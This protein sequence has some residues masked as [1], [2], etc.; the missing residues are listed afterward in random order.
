M[1]EEQAR[2]CVYCGSGVG[3]FERD[4][5]WP[6]RFGGSDAPENRE[7]SCRRCNRLKSH[8]LWIPLHRSGVLLAVCWE[9][10][11]VI[12]PASVGGD[13]V[14]DLSFSWGA[15]AWEAG[16]LRKFALAR[17]YRPRALRIARVIDR[18]KRQENRDPETVTLIAPNGR[19]SRD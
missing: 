12:V 5:V 16:R 11:D 7:W 6:K 8:R 3:P 17:D 14:H 15:A 4:H 13:A 19:P 18:H 9:R 2:R 10:L 1:A